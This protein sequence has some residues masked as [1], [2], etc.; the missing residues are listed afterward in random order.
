M[1]VTRYLKLV[2]K[3]FWIILLLEIVAI[4]STVYYTQSQP[5]QYTTRSTIIINPRVPNQLVPYASADYSYNLTSN[6]ADEYNLLIKSDKFATKLVGQVGFPISLTELKASYSSKLAPNTSV[7]YIS[8]TSNTPQKAQKIANSVTHLFLAEGVSQVNADTQQTPDVV[9]DTIKSQ[10]Q[11]LKDLQVEIDSLKTQI[12]KLAEANTASPDTQTTQQLITLRQQLKDDLTT[13]SQLVVSITDAESKTNSLTNRDSASLVDEATLPTAPDGANL[14]RNLLFA[15]VMALALGVGVIILLDFLDYTI[16]SSQELTQLTGK[17]TL[18]LVPVVRATPSTSVTTAAADSSG[19]AV[20]AAANAKNLSKLV[21]T[22]TEFKSAGSESYRALRTNILFCNLNEEKDETQEANNRLVERI[23]DEDDL[24]MM[25]SLLITS[26]IPGEGK[27]LTAANLAVTFAQA[28]N[29]VILVDAD[30]R[31]PTQHRLFGLPNEKGFSNLVLAGPEHLE[32][33]LKETGV[34]NLQLITAGN[35]PPNPSE[36]LTSFKAVKVTTAIRR[37]AD[38]IIF[39]SPPVVLVS[40][41][42]ILAN[43]VDGVLL[44]VRS[45]STRRDTITKAVTG[46]KKVG[47]NLV[48]T[49]LNRVESRDDGGYYYYQYNGY[50]ENGKQPSKDKNKR[51]KDRSGAAR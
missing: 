18:G 24:I 29:R 9:N 6:L 32:E 33:H 40:D 12:A 4:V 14:V 49:V 30:L 21:V 5:P 45:G 22:A 46:L 26:A 11:G 16:R 50:L 36:L 31:Q 51:G 1:G 47:A 13:Q 39:D 2:V 42:A 8:A 38:F 23:V 10:R 25:K 20:L 7:Y 3:R 17:T 43:R 15:L 35:P 19:T 44:V 41:A 48:G 34:P 27:S 28:G 37:A